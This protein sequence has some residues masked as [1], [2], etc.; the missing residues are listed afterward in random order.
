[1]LTGFWAQDL[2]S[3]NSIIFSLCILF[4]HICVTS[5]DPGN[6]EMADQKVKHPVSAIFLLKPLPLQ[7]LFF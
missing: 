3:M 6:A 4:A 2:P 1:M 7:L 5:Q